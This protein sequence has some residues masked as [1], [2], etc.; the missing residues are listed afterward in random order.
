VLTPTQRRRLAVAAEAD[1]VVRVV[2]AAELADGSARAATS[3]TLTWRFRAEN[4]RDAVWAAAPNF[5]W[6]ATSWQGHLAMAY[7]RPSAA[8]NWTDAADQ[9]RMSIAEYS[10]RWFPYPWPQI[11]A[12]E[13]PISG[14]EYPMIAMEARGRSVEDL[15]S[16]VTHEIGHMWYP[17]IV[18]S[19]ERRHM[20]Q[21]E[22]FDTFINTFAEARRYPEQGDQMA[23]AAR[24]RGLIEQVMRAGIDK[25]I[26]IHPDRIAPNLLG[27]SA[28]I[29]PSVGLQLLRQEI[30]GPAA[31]DDAF[32]SYTARWA[33]RH[34][35]P[36]DFFRSMEDVAG[37]RLDWF[38]RGWF[39]ENAR[40][41]Q[42]IDS[43]A[44]RP[45]GDTEQVVVVY[46]NR[47]R[48]VLP[49]RA[50]FTFDDGSVEEIGYPAEVWS[51]NTRAYRRNYR[52]E[53][54]HLI[55]IELDPEHRLVDIDRSNDH[56]K[57]T[58]G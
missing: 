39:L 31:F 49:I 47:E 54:R 11:S 18:G 40:F 9:S 27:V 20:W 57:A 16:V 45:D 17:M 37:R 3:G 15:F 42:A 56:W 7:Y 29:K 25:P 19:N 26:E 52:F 8:A 58:G 24:E 33:F 4:V 28:Y 6:D 51:T 44:V 53:G 30:L 23:R 43:V 34:P 22:G 48:G 14:M 50:R 1:T 36:T 55:G 13:G 21:D 10:E 38:W 5:Q 12:V 32:R 35:T 2:T 41:D 46:G